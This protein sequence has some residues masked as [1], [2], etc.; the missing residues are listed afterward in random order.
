LGRRSP[1]GGTIANDADVAAWL[2]KAVDAA[3]VPG[4]AYDLSPFFRLS[5]AAS[6]TVLADA[7][8]RFAH[9]VATL[10]CP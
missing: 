9:A 5:T 2:L 8:D 10:K 7:I 1:D 4:S 3:A 6:E